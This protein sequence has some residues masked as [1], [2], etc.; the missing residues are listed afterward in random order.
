M[1]ENYTLTMIINPRRVV[2]IRVMFGHNLQTVLRL[3]SSIQTFTRKLKTQLYQLDN[4]TGSFDVFK[5]PVTNVL[6]I[7]IIIIIYPLARNRFIQF[8]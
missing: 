5:L 7:I 8:C 6:I 1:G 2:G 3:Q 4:V